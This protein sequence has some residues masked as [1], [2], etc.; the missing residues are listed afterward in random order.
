VLLLLSCCRSFHA[1]APHT[2]LF[3]SHYCSSHIAVRFTLSLLTCCCSSRVVAFSIVL[4]IM[5][6]SCYS[7]HVIIFAPLSLCYNYALILSCC[8]CGSFFSCYNSSLD[9]AF[10]ALLL[11]HCSCV[12]F[13]SCYNSSL[14]VILLALLLLL[15]CSF[16]PVTFLMLS[17]P[18]HCSFHIMA[19]FKHM[20]AQPLL[21]FSCCHCC[22]SCTPT[23][24]C[25]ASMVLPL[26]LPCAS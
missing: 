1:I 16:H 14:D 19:H 12:L 20:L 13:L 26:P 18:L 23:L 7:F 25:L 10:L 17:F 4:L 9:V 11:S 15:H 5:Q 6:L 3:I 2:L 21:F 24:F 8:K 22:S